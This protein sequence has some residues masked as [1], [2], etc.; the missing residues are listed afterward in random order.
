M[1]VAYVPAIGDGL[2]AGVRTRDN[3]SIQIDC[4][5]RHDADAALHKGLL[6]IDPH[7]FIL[8]HFHVDHY[9]GLFR[10]QHL[11]NVPRPRI[12][13]LYF[14]R[15]PDFAEKDEFR[16]CLDAMNYRVLGGTTGSQEADLLRLLSRINTNPFRY[17]PL[18][19][20]DRFS[21]GGADF[22]VVWPPR[23]I[24][25]TDT[26]KSVRD[27]I[28]QFKAAVKEDGQL[29]CIY[30]GLEAGA[31]KETF[32]SVMRV[33][34]P[35]VLHPACGG[36]AQM[37][38]RMFPAPAVGLPPVVREANKSLRGAANHVSLAFYES[39]RFLFMGDLEKCEISHVVASL[40]VKG[41]DHF[42]VTI[43]SHHGTHWDDSF[44]GI[45]SWYT[46]CSVG[47]RL[48]GHVDPNYRS[49]SGTCCITHLHGDIEVPVVPGMG[50][51]AQSR[52]NGW[53]FFCGRGPGY[54]LTMPP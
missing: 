5:S 12:Q 18:S 28:K 3:W 50:C 15:L 4:G 42:L 1:I 13:H 10:L 41:Q 16:L 46:I 14:P 40:Q 29:R 37:P 43:A 20:G 47:Q 54:L 22:E 49:V 52:W 9:N 33:S 39:D 31:G 45:R 7:V 17:Q 51:L 25:G 8:S 23:R 26:V 27:A 19:Q 2:A 36:E 32:P 44:R 34:E 6:R 48:V 53:P 38:E 30:E 21:V 11:A 35:G 24:D